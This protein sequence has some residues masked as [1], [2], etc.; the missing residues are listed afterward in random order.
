MEVRSMA[1][2]ANRLR[3]D[4]SMTTVAFSKRGTPASRGVVNRAV[5]P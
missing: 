2:Q 3:E 4:V 5:Q 1:N